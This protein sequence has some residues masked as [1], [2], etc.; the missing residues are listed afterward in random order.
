MTQCWNEQEDRRPSFNRVI[1]LL[2]E[3]GGGRIPSL[4][5]SMINHLEKQ[6]EKLEKVV[7]ER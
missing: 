7:R 4:V 1:S 2:Q 3:I 5:D 6:T